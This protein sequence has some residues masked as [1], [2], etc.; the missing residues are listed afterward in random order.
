MI[1]LLLVLIIIIG[2]RLL[3]RR[4]RN[5]LGNEL[6]Y[7]TFWWWLPIV[8]YFST[9]VQWYAYDSSTYAISYY[10]IAYFLL[11]LSR[12]I[13]M[14]YKFVI[15]AK[16]WGGGTT[17]ELLTINE[18]RINGFFL[19]GLIGVLLYIVDYLNHNSITKD[20]RYSVLTIWGT[21]G[22]F[23]CPILLTVGFYLVAH[24]L[25]EEKRF[26]IK[27]LFCLILY[28]LPNT[29]NSGRESLLIVF[30]GLL[31]IYSISTA[32][33]KGIKQYFKR[34]D[35]S[36]YILIGIALVIIVGVMVVVSAS[37]FGNLE[38]N[39]FLLR[40]RLPEGLKQKLDSLRVTKNLAYNFISYFAQQVPY[41]SFVFDN[42]SGPYYLGLYEMNILS[43]RLPSRSF[44]NGNNIISRVIS[45]VP[46][47]FSHGWPTGM[48]S[49]IYDFGKIGALIA[50][51]C[52]GYFI[53][54]KRAE[55]T[56]TGSIRS[57]V[58]I[59][60]FCSLSMSLIQNGVFFQYLQ[61][62]A[63]IWWG[64]IFRK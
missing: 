58:A 19:I 29:L 37:R 10:I 1:V 43:R 16:N 12:Q 28:L 9:G 6:T 11:V 14:K 17:Y 4:K 5:M 56:R 8:L 62:G 55:F 15:N 26:S 53:G 44:Y 36:K 2:F 54:R 47:V 33:R 3:L 61:F 63:F 20:S 49:L 64:I 45:G 51:V 42:Y 22:F 34:S 52:I 13:G 60:L 31:V 23:F 25:I 59:A 27:G 46:T 7:I 18:K 35:L 41:F 39:A 57:I 32:D 30:V 21:L 48:A 40:A 24:C 38:A 50:I